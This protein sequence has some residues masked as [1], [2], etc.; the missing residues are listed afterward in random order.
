MRITVITAGRAKSDPARDLYDLYAGRLRWPLVL[1]EIEERRALPPAELTKREG[2]LILK[3]VPAGA[4]LVALD[5][6]GK[7]VNSRA[8]AALI[9]RWQDE[10]YADLA[11]AIG[12]AEGLS[13][14]VLE[15]ADL[16][17]SLGPMTWPH[18]LVRALLVE[19]L[20][21]AQAILDG[22]PYHRD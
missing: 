6:R 12:G 21:R 10:G 2:E 4:R 5:E 22:H 1:R 20:F 7:T 17:L 15:R 19:Q 3:A 11:F 14:A 13:P 9:G 8:F 16:R 18:L